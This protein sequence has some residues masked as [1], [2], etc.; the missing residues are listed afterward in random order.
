M[1]YDKGELEKPQEK[2]EPMDGVA[3]KKEQ[4]VL[5]DPLKEQVIKTRVA[6]EVHAA[7][8]GHAKD[9]IDEIEESDKGIKYKTKDGASGF[10]PRH[11]IDVRQ[12]TI[13]DSLGL[14]ED[15]TRIEIGRALIEKNLREIKARDK[16]D[17]ERFGLPENASSTM[18]ARVRDIEKQEKET[19]GTG[20][21]EEAF[22]DYMRAL[23]KKMLP[24]KP[25]IRDLPKIVEGSDRP[26]KEVKIIKP[27][28]IDRLFRRKQ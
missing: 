14:K 20:M 2:L 11:E 10:M 4:P 5:K 24:K 28:I 23:V 15:S 6:S 9:K 17:K 1:E 25:E 3:S 19:I 26:T 18:L 12:K 22:A 21:S 13:A 16:A 8:L 27:S 7:I